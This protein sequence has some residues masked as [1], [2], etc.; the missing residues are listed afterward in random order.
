MFLSRC[1]VLNLNSLLFLCAVASPI[2]T[3]LGSTDFVVPPGREAAPFNITKG[4]DHDLWF[5]EGVGQKIGRITTAGVIKEFPIRGA[6]FLLGIAAGSD[7]NMWFTDQL[8]GKIG[9]ISQAG[10]AQE[11]FSLPAGSYPQGI[12]AGPDGNLWFMDQ[13]KSGLYTIGK[14]TVAGAITEYPTN[15]NAGVFI[16]NYLYWAEIAAG[17]DG[18]LWFVNPQLASFGGAGANLVGKI[19]TAGVITT[20]PTNDTRWESPPARTATYGVS[21]SATLRKSRLRGW[22]PS[23]RLRTLEAIPA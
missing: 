19:T 3:A 5:T 16:P 6:Q 14:I 21:R 8:T 23:T 11:E 9:H 15:L 20:Y 1:K 13:K 18:N 2:H 22:R 10:A 12:T 17:P 7:G 4:P